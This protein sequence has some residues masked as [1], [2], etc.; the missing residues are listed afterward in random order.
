[1][2]AS[3]LFKRFKALAWNVLCPDLIKNGYHKS[4]LFWSSGVVTVIVL[5]IFYKRG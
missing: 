1:M 4:I 5:D 3:V 2:D